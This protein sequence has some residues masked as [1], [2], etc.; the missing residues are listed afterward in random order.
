MGL[1][2]KDEFD[3]LR[4]KELAMNLDENGKSQGIGDVDKR[5]FIRPRL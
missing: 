3:K 4:D 1:Y 2:Q 5:G